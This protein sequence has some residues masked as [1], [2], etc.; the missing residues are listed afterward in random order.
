MEFEWNQLF[1]TDR[2]H[3]Y[4]KINGNLGKGDDAV[5]NTEKSKEFWGDIYNVEKHHKE[6]PECLNDIKN[7]IEVN[8]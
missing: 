2:K 5:L 8:G 4:Q 6:N 7:K 1:T 3:F